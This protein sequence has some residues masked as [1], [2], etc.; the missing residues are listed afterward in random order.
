MGRLPR[1]A[2]IDA[3]VV[4]LTAPAGYGK[5]TLIAEWAQLDERPFVRV[6][7]SERENEACTFA[8][9]V[10]RALGSMRPRDHAYRALARDQDVG[11]SLELLGSVLGQPRNPF[12]LVLDDVHVLSSPGSDAVVHV[13]VDHLPR[14][15]QLVL[16][17]RRRSQFHLARLRAQHELFELDAA[18]LAFRD[19][20]AEAMLSDCGVHLSREA[21]TAL[22]ERAEGWPA[23][24]YLATLSLP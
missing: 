12:V 1:L 3:G 20:E 10:I 5:T 21:I 24:L 14:G 18:D 9:S 2:E 8:D 17:G 15:S 4:V 16:V 22:T 7:M 11:A 19:D 13:L 23:G 6:T